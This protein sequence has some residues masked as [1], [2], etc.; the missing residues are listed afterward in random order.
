VL[1]GGA[2]GKVRTHGGP[3]CVELTIDGERWRAE[4]RRFPPLAPAR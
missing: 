3:S 4:L 1:N 2:A